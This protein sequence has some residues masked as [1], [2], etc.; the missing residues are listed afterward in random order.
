MKRIFVAIMALGALVSC[1]KDEL[2]SVNRQAIQFGNA[3][4]ENS[5]RATDPSYGGTTAS[6]TSFNVWGAIKNT[7]NNVTSYLPVF[8]G[9]TVSGTVGTGSVWTPSTTQYWVEDALYNFAGLV[10]AGDEDVE[11]GADQL[12]AT[13]DFTLTTG[14]VDLLYARSATDI[15]GKAS[16]N[17]LVAM[18]FNHLLSKVKFTVNNNSTAA[19]A[20]SFL[21]K[22]IVVNGPKT[23]TYTVSTK[24]WTSATTDD[25]TEFSTISVTGG[26]AS[27]ECA[28]ELL[29]IPGDVSVTFTVDIIYSGKTIATHTYT[30]T[31][32]QAIKVG[33]AYNFV[34]NVSVGDPIQFSVTSAPTWVNGNTTPSDTKT[35]IPLTVTQAN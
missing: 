4:V 13:V 22:D 10:N 31:T 34:I 3:F 15:V 19:S 12:P 11:L 32:A 26:T 2:V 24:E 28:S 18:N 5:T 1:S 29:L 6:L 30:T 17:G 33:H 21:V 25:F 35:H 7:S 23:E 9:E 20:Y 8:A 27:A 14:K 16:S